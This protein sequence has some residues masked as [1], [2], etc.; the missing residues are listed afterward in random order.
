MSFHLDLNTPC[1]PSRLLL[2]LQ[3][4]PSQILM[5]LKKKKIRLITVSRVPEFNGIG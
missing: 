4:D 2:S 5:M 3:L 1:V